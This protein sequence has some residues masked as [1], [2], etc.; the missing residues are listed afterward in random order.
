MERG[1][2]EPLEFP[3]IL[4]PMTEKWIFPAVIWYAA[5]V[6]G[7][8]NATGPTEPEQVSLAGEPSYR[9]AAGC[10]RPADNTTERPRSRRW[11]NAFCA[12]INVARNSSAPLG[13]DQ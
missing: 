9:V 3:A 1:V 8:A 13:A 5:V 7:L 2:T 4:P 12:P 10:S 11:E 6:L